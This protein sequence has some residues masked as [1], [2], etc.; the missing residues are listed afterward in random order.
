[1]KLH[2]SNRFLACLMA[3]VMAITV[4][5]GAIPAISMAVETDNVDTSD[6]M[7]GTTFEAAE[8]TVK[9]V[10]RKQI[11]TIMVEV[12]GDPAF[13]R[14]GSV[15]GAANYEAEM[16]KLQNGV[17]AS[18]EN[19]VGKKIDILHQHTLLFNGF[20]FKG[21]Y[22]WIKK[23]NESVSGARAF[24]PMEWSVPETI[25]AADVATRTIGSSQT[26]ADDAW[27]AGYNGAGTAVAIL[28]TGLVIGHKAFAV[29]PTG[30]PKYTQSSISTIVS[31]GKLNAKTTAANLYYSAKIPFRYNYNTNTNDVLNT[32]AGYHG[33]HVAG[34][35][36]GNPSAGT[37]KGI[38]YNAQLVIMQVFNTDGG[39]SWDTILPALEDCAY[40]GVDAANMSLGSDCGFTAYYDPSYATTFE[41]L[42]QAGVNL[43]VAAGNSGTNAITGNAWGGYQLSMN[44]DFG[45]VGAP[46]TWPESL[47]VAACN[48]SGVPTDFSSW[49]TTSDLKLKPEIMAPGYNIYSS[50]GSGTSSYS[51]LSGTSMACPHV[52]GGMALITK[53]VEN[54]FPSLSAEE[55]LNM[56][57]NLLISTATPTAKSTNL[58]Y[59]PRLQGSGVMS[60][61]K[62]ITANA[63]IS[64]DYNVRPLME[65]G[66]DK[67]KSGVYTIEF[68][69]T[70]FGTSSQTYTISANVQTETMSSKSVS[71]SNISARTINY[72]NGT[73]YNLTSNATV[74]TNFTNN[75]V[76][77]AAGA[78]EHVVMTITLNSTA[79]A[80]LDKF[81]C[82]MYVEGFIK[83]TNSSSSGTSLG[84]PYLSFYGDWNYPA[85][86]DHGYY[87]MKALGQD[88]YQ[89][90]KKLN[91]IGYLNGST[92]YGLGINP[93]V[94]MQ[95]WLPDRSSI[96]P[97]GD[98]KYDSVN[99]AYVG[100]I[101]NSINAYYRLYTED[102][103]E[104]DSLLEWNFE[105]KS[106]YYQSGTYSYTYLQCGVDYCEF[107]EWDGGSS[108]TDSDGNTVNL[109]HTYS[110][111]DTAVIAI[112][113]ELDYNGFTH[114]ANQGSLWKTP[115]TIDTEAP[116]VVSMRKDGN[117][118]YVTLT[119]NHYA[120][121]AAI[122][123]GSSYTSSTLL[124]SAGIF[125][126]TRGAQ[127]TVALDTNGNNTVYLLIGDYAC[128][129]LKQ[130]IDVTAVGS[131]PIAVTGVTIPETL[132]LN[133]NETGT[134]T[135]T[136]TPSDA[137]DYAVAWSSSNT[138]VATVDNGNVTAKAYGTATIT[139]T[140]TDNVSGSTF[141]DTCEVTVAPVNVTGI[142]VSP[143]TVEVLVDETATL[144]AT[145]SP[146]NASDATIVWTTSNASVATVSNG[147]VTGIKAGTAVITATVTDNLNGGTFSASCTVNVT[148]FEGYLVADQF[149]D[150]GEYIIVA[151]DAYA[152]SNNTVGTTGYYLSPV[153][154]TISGDECRV[155]STVNVNEILW[156]AE[157]NTTDGFT[158]KS[159]D[160]GNYMTLNSSEYLYPGTNAITWKYDGTDLANSAD[161]EGY[162][163]L[164][165][166]SST[167][168]RFTTGKNT[169]NSIKIYKKITSSAPVET[170]YTVTFKDWDGTVLSTQSVLE[171]TA[172][173]A[174]ADPTR[175]GYHFVAWD[176]AFDN[177]TAD[178]TVTAQYTAAPII[179]MLGASYRTTPN[180][181]IRFGGQ[182]DKNF[183]TNYITIT[184]IGMLII[185]ENVL[186]GAELTVD[187][188]KVLNVNITSFITNNDEMYQFV[189]TLTNL[190]GSLLD[191][192]IAARAYVE[193]TFNGEVYRLYADTVIRSYNELAQQ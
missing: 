87:W 78:T 53:Y 167:T 54:K 150:G 90:N 38:A 12:D 30:T 9:Q 124:D 173:T 44:P 107:P 10:N 111:G 103:S 34:I 156:K 190:S 23:I 97:N 108:I 148:E 172:A 50:Y 192:R 142:T 51:S 96:S 98:G 138:N 174:P 47:S 137:N 188:S 46:S 42:R 91:T 140:V 187:T 158:L 8:S 56:V 57:D 68:D 3:L 123:S 136:I 166:S 100:V 185:P 60:L 112:G 48:S 175:E 92:V 4:F 73:P 163:Y 139:C 118:L 82:G 58:Y 72:I 31:Q 164:S 162:Y 94:D 26:G 93:Y 133:L 64:C 182:L 62:A 5:A 161:S 55:K 154:V 59:S 79:K 28:D 66:D 149:E 120:A 22:G 115:V 20:S 33:T 24:L 113:M 145:V 29:S 119:D 146:A 117:T 152:V 157:G 114:E 186:N 6:A 106:Y 153:S 43:A 135:A 121:Y 75:R 69:V 83:L 165:Y 128:N 129:E 49:G 18:I 35:V 67:T 183:D 141:T 74:S 126:Q 104:Y 99:V 71:S 95:D 70:N 15:K 168:T 134:L 191:R 122:Y 39:A 80:Y 131:E 65:I 81:E 147:V 184:K 45:I 193:Y 169:G 179:K 116:S 77:V 178:T 61:D 189:A 36:A 13:K 27:S 181:G 1:M 159:L 14:A 40:L 130:T 160:D 132:A 37:I 110:N 17:I 76:T 105:N 151:S 2:S 176:V 84:A 32:G 144:T 101:R 25:S 102:M 155:A 41:L 89:S 52:A 171:G 7:Q 177:I 21:E 143:A 63:Y 109:N 16:L 88:C 180:K 19:L 127:T 86:M 85:T 170:Y 11:V 125:E